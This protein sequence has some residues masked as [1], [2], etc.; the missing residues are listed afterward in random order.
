MGGAEDCIVD[1]RGRGGCSCEFQDGGFGQPKVRALCDLR[2]HGLANRERWFRKA[3]CKAHASDDRRPQSIDVVGD[4]NRGGCGSL[5][6]PV[7]EYLATSPIKG[8]ILVNP[9]EKI[10]RLI[11]DNNRPS[12]HCADRVS[13][14]KRRDPL[15]SIGLSVFLAR[16]A[17]KLN[18]SRGARPASWRTRSCRFPAARRREGSR[19]G[20]CASET[21]LR[22][23]RSSGESASP[24]GC[25]KSF[26]PMKLERVRRAGD[27]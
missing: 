11:D 18:R 10:I 19:R 21:P 26:R 14:Q 17:A 22:L 13:D 27:R 15:A 8:V 4:P 7:H 1:Q 9:S 12:R 2:H 16:L 6:E 24:Q 20:A 5:D 23:Q 25:S 3:E